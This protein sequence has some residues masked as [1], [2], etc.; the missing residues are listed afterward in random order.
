MECAK[1]SVPLDYAKPSGKKI[2]LALS[3]VPHTAAHS[4]GPLL[5]NP[6]GPGGSG[7][8][9]AGFVARS[10]PKKV[11]AQYDIVGFDPRG[12]GSSE[13]AL[14][15]KPG[16]FK[17]IRPDS[18]PHSKAEESK[19]I[20]R[21]ASFAK[22][23][24]T[25]YG[26]LLKHIHTRDAVRDMDRIR[27]AL[28]AARINY[29]GYS[30]GTY[31]G[32]VY[33]K[34][35]PQR[36]RRLVL[37][38]IVD[39]NGVW[40]EDNISQDYAFDARHRAFASWVAKNN[41]TYHLGTHGKDVLKKWYAMRE[42]MRTNP[43]KG[44]VGPAELEDSF[45]P[46]GYYNG[47]WPALAAGFSAYVRHGDQQA[48]VDL[49][50]NF[51]ATDDTNGYSI[52]TSVQC[53]DAAW[54]RDWKT[55]HKDTEKVYAKAPFMAWNNAWYN[56]PCAF[57]PTTSLKPTNVSNNR[58]PAAL[59]FQATDDAATPYSG[60]VA[61]HKLLKK[62]RLVVEEGGGNHGITLSG[63]ACLD[64]WLAKYLDTGALP[65]SRPGPD[66]TCKALPDPKPSATRK[67]TG[68]GVDLHTLVSHRN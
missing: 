32:A 5:V 37:D 21:A 48:L 36:V 59:L 54:P 9:L 67:A 14:D 42:K 1:I 61:V 49:Y 19:N 6:G 53:R 26:S 65:A 3:R 38:S 58:I 23:C 47:Y 56:A 46:G 17:P 52:Y 45:I 11:A 30:Y 7:L 10:L 20:Q 22:A 40:Y 16:Y 24:G 60:G 34:L 68:E 18:V 66:A 4:Q 41:T 64:K 57:W 50:D 15:C 27:A 29:F 33:A 25:K 43:A 63:N 44:K 51:G 62:S 12:V 28:G 2:R 13:P 35:F 39:P 31:L 55:W 8:G